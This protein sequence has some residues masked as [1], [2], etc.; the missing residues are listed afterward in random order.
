LETALAYEA[1]FKRSVSELFGGV[2][3]KAER[4]V[5]ERARTLTERTGRRKPNQQSARK[6]E[7][8]ADLATA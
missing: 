7:A 3:Q 5:A 1:I 2:Y 6:R 8:L 4:E